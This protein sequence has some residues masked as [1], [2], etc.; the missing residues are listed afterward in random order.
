MVNEAALTEFHRQLSGIP[1]RPKVPF[2]SPKAAKL[3]K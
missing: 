1:D 3:L 2:E